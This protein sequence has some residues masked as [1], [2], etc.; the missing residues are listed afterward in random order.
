M[1]LDK[2]KRGMVVELTCN[3]ETGYRDYLKL[4]YVERV[5]IPSDPPHITKYRRMWRYQPWRNNQWDTT[6]TCHISGWYAKKHG[7]ELSPLERLI[8]FG[9]A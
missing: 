3:S 1:A 9:E 5:D 7:R 4:L 8:L 2:F 6:G